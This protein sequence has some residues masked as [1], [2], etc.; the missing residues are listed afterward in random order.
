MY[1]KC[2]IF[3]PIHGSSYYKQSFRK[4]HCFWGSPVFW[5]YVFVYL[6]ATGEQ[7]A[8]EAPS[9]LGIDWRSGG[10]DRWADLPVDFVEKWSSYRAP[11]PSLG[12]RLM[13]EIFLF[14]WPW[15]RRF[16]RT[17]RR[18]ARFFAFIPRFKLGWSIEGAGASKVNQLFSVKSL[19]L[20]SDHD[21]WSLP[22]I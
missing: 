13:R 3:G 11:V 8:A 20:E 19:S 4:I 21:W 6:S 5:E 17:V 15:G 7:L 10:Y 16:L 14:C 2:S 22:Q 9:R 18:V 12:D 1:C